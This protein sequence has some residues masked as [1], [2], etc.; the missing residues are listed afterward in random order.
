MY[1]RAQETLGVSLTISK[2][3]KK[4]T[5]GTQGLATHPP[6]APKIHR[7]EEEITLIHCSSSCLQQTLLTVE[8][9]AAAF[10]CR[11]LWQTHSIAGA[12][13]ERMLLTVEEETVSSTVSS[14]CS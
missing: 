12:A 9:A 14:V 3:K 1:I 8:D 4:I 5:A 2:K 7:L 10:A 6:P 13:N 11:L